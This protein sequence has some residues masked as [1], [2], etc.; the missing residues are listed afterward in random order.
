MGISNSR[1]EFFK[2]SLPA[3]AHSTS[4]DDL[5]VG[6]WHS[7]LSEHR[8]RWIAE[9][10][11]SPGNV[12]LLA[13]APRHD[14]AFTLGERRIPLLV[15]GAPTD[16]YLGTLQKG[17]LGLAEML[18]VY[19]QK[20]WFIIVGDDTFV[21]LDRL[22]HSLSAL[23]SSEDHCVGEGQIINK[24]WWRGFR[25]NGG[26]GIATSVAL[27]RKL[28]YSGELSKWANESYEARLAA[29][30]AGRDLGPR[31]VVINHMFFFI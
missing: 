31:F 3:C 6:I 1:T 12:V 2:S 24:T 19:P 13:A 10:W 17:L 25:L 27:T 21:R 7:I 23:D 15:T 8:I 18:R 26:A 28:A 14:G 11:Y 22:A 16:D 9:S 20:K 29:N 5:L 30:H 4:R